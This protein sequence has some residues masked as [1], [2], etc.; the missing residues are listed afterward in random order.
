[1]RPEPLPR[2]VSALP[3]T[4]STWQRV[5][6]SF[7]L[8]DAI[9]KAVERSSGQSSTFFVKRQGQ[10]VLEMY[11][12]ATGLS[13]VAGSLDKIAISSTHFRYSKLTVAVIFGCIESQ[14]RKVEHLLRHAPE[15]KSHPLLMVGV[16]A[17]LHRHRVL[18]IVKDALDD[19]DTATWKLGLDGETRPEVRRSFELSR[20]LRNCRLTAKRAE[21]EIRTSKGQLH[22]M[23]EQIEE[24]VV[25]HHTQ[26]SP[27]AQHSREADD[28]FTM[29]TMRF[30]HRF[31]EISLEFDV[32]MA[33]CRMTF[34]DMTYTEELVSDE[35][36]L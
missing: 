30:K 5:T 2:L 18:D 14:M 20:E 11:T 23:M 32:L 3:F 9:Q 34:D 13:R 15:A 17:E 33:Q 26:G 1:M 36:S 16:F 29:N 7:Y 27:R 10:E 25:Q 6:R 19:C 21:E 12:A 28:D 31:E 35:V 4:Q 22:K 24:F 8:H